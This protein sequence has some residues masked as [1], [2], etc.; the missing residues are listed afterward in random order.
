MLFRSRQ[1]V[2]LYRGPLLEGCVEEWVLPERESRAEQCLA[3]LET[4]ER[5][6]RAVIA[7]PA[8]MRAASQDAGMM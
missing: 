1:A 8:A 7:A 5:V 3:A 6:E 2:E 4:C